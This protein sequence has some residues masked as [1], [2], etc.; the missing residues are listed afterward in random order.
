[1]STNLERFKVFLL[2]L[3]WDS[4]SVW[5][6]FS[7][8]ATNG[9]S[10]CCLTALISVAGHFNCCSGQQPAKKSQTTTAALYCIFLTHAHKRTVPDAIQGNGTQRCYVFFFS[11]QVR[12]A[13]NAAAAL[14]VPGPGIAFSCDMLINDASRRFTFYKNN[15]G[16]N[17][18]L[19]A[20]LAERR[21]SCD[22]PRPVRVSAARGR[23]RACVRTF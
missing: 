10:Y 21:R 19:S 4:E 18:S 22:V 15:G 7:S 23:S 16:K 14:S 3:C 11:S 8:V 9:G 17:V 2:Q 1:M 6:C 13:D 12:I 5:F 20:G